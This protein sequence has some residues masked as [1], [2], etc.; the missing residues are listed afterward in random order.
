MAPRVSPSQRIREIA[1]L[2][3][4]A[5]AGSL[6]DHVERVA[7]LAVRLVM[8]SALEAEVSEFLG[9]DRYQRGA[10]EQVGSRAAAARAGRCQPGR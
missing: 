4:G 10:R 9:R 6:L 2:I 3:A 7:R 5:T 8:R 1:E